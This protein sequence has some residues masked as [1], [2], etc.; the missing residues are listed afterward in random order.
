MSTKA[1][2]LQGALLRRASELVTFI[3]PE[4][5]AQAYRLLG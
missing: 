4:P 3:S 5:L 2:E 1:G